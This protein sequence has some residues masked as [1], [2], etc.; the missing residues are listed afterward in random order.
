MPLLPMC[1]LQFIAR[2]AFILS[3]ICI[4]HFFIF[5]LDLY[6]NHRTWHELT[7]TLMHIQEKVGFDGTCL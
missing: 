4:K 3:G 1:W 5:L 6:Y 7:L 2:P